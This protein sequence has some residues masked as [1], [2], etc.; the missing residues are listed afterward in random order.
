MAVVS[1]KQIMDRLRPSL[2]GQQG[3][4]AF[5]AQI[6]DMGLVISGDDDHG[7]TA[8][9]I[10]KPGTWRMYANGSRQISSKV[11]SELVGRWDRFQFGSR[12]ISTYGEDSLNDIAD[13]LYELDLRINKGNLGEELGFLL[14]SVFAQIAGFE[15]ELSPA[16]SIAIRKAESTGAPYFNEKTGRLHIGDD[17]RSTAEK[18]GAVPDDI[19]SKELIYVGALLRAYCEQCD[20]QGEKP[21]PN[22]IPKKYKEHFID[23]RKAFFAAEWV[24]GQ[25]WD[26]IDHGESVFQQFLEEIRQG[27]WETNLDDYPTQVK[28]LF[29]TLTQST[30]VRLSSIGLDQIEGFIDVWSRKGACHELVNEGKLSWEDDNGI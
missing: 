18:A 22:D 5:T 20:L 11:A 12:L 17:F 25:S 4:G 6:I 27:V 24:K 28:R 15:K 16:I 2:Q 8:T 23:Q 10:V 29:A 30:N 7:Q 14:Y 9:D 3:L 1:F 19:R 26:C 21:K 13:S